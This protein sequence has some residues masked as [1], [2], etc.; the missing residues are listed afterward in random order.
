MPVARARSRSYVLAS[1]IDKEK[2]LASSSSA[3]HLSEARSFD[4]NEAQIAAAIA[5]RP[6]SAVE[7]P[8]AVVAARCQTGRAISRRR[9]E[10]EMADV[11]YEAV[12]FA[13]CRRE[14]PIAAV[15]DEVTH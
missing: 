9:Q 2:A 4:R 13:G 11:T 15:V 7:R 5:K 1:K 6:S 12:P 14:G 8:P 10:R 3:R